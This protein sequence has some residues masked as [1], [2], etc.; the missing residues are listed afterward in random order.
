MLE[1][2]KLSEEDS[3]LSRGRSRDLA[4]PR[5]DCHGAGNDD[6]R[7][8][9]DGEDHGATSSERWSSGRVG[10]PVRS[11]SACGLGYLGVR[12]PAAQV[13]QTGFFRGPNAPGPKRSGGRACTPPP[14]SHALGPRM[15]PDLLDPP[16]AQRDL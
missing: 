15:V 9:Y 13:V 14:L 11:C 3:L 8:H 5:A 7:E 12:R 10:A 16:R 2:G 6:K 4:D 1:G